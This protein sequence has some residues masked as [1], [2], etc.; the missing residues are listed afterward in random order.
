MNTVRHRLARGFTLIELMITIAIIGILAAIA[1]FA[2]QD[3]IIRSQVAEGL[4]LVSGPQLALAEWQS[5]HPS[6]PNSGNPGNNTSLGLASPSSIAGNYV[7]SVSVENGGVIDLVY[8]NKAN[9]A[10]AGAANKCVLS[11]ITS[12]PGAIRWQA[13]CG[14][15]DRYLPQAWRP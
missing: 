10:I 6:F 7:S 15:P 5:S 12:S 14:F 4:S 13:A 9:T 11:P 2:Y 3:Y 1:M 8:G